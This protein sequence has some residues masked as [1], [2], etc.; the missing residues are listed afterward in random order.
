MNRKPDLRVM[1]ME[2]VA[3]VPKFL[4][5]YSTSGNTTLLPFSSYASLIMPTMWILS[6]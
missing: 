1:V 3:M 6:W 4:H 5:L 2:G